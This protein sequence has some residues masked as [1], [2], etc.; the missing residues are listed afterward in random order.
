MGTLVMH[1]RLLAGFFNR[2]AGSSVYNFNLANSLHS[3]GHDVSVVAFAP[4]PLLLPELGATFL[5][6]SRVAGTI[7][8]RASYPINIVICTLKIRRAPLLR[9][10]V[11]VAA[12]HFFV[13]GHATRFR[14]VPWIYL[15]HSRILEEDI[16]YRY[17]GIARAIAVASG[18]WLQ[19][20]ALAHA[21]TTLRFH[22]TS[23]KAMMESFGLSDAHP[24]FV[25]PPGVQPP[26]EEL[27][28]TRH[29]TPRPLRLLSVGALTRRK[30]Q[31]LAIETLA[32]LKGIGSWHYDIVGG[33]E[34]R[35]TLE[36]AAKIAGLDHCITFHGSTSDVSHFYRDADVLL[37]P[38]LADNAPLVVLEAMSFGLPVI[39]LDDDARGVNLCNRTFII[40]GENGLLAPSIPDYVEVLTKLLTRD[41]DIIRMG[42]NARRTILNRFTWD[43]HVSRFEAKLTELA[44]ARQPRVA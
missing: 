32:K 39:G 34:E 22:E 41:L 35:A 30:N 8:W 28:P 26:P 33:G 12:E 19:K 17:E 5:P 7:L 9:P 20:W 27:V 10:D 44:N 40:N 31:I 43:L 25:N 6:P 37:F 14:D 29:N 13:L 36:K 2:D 18:R 11:C 4:S 1:I 16:S 24:F 15:P 23:R 3:R 21:T 38:S 42:Q